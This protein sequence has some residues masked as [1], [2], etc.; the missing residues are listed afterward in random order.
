[1]FWKILQFPFVD[2]IL[3]FYI[4]NHGFYFVAIINGRPIME[5]FYFS[6]K[7]TNVFACFGKP[8]ELFFCCF[9]AGLNT[10]SPTYTLIKDRTAGWMRR[11]HVGESSKR[12]E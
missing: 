2:I 4:S 9:S 7:L 5:L 1:M 12:Y 3:H 11:S 6:D 10:Q 8:Y